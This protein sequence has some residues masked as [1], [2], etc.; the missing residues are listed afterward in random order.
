MDVQGRVGGVGADVHPGGGQRLERRLP[1]RCVGHDDT[2]VDP[3]P[4]GLP[5]RALDGGV[6]HLFVVDIELAAR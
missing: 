1:V 3:A 2:D 4:G 6:S 5:E